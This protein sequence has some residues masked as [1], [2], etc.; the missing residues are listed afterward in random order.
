MYN[1]ICITIMHLSGQFL[2][3]E[4]VF[5]NEILLSVQN[6]AATSIVKIRTTLVAIGFRRW[7]HI[8]FS[9]VVA[10]IIQAP[11]CGATVCRTHH[12]LDTEWGSHCDGNYV[13]A[14]ILG[15]YISSSLSSMMTLI[16][17]WHFI[18]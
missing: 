16:G 3:F 6:A 5:E 8:T 14:Q 17:C 7:Q 9:K 15:A 1:Y 12:R 10:S 11:R 13:C 4:Q 18:R 2:C